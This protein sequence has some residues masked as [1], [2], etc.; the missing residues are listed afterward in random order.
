[1][2]LDAVPPGTDPRRMRPTVAA[3]ESPS[4]FATSTALVGM[5][6][7]W[8]ITPKKMGNGRFATRARS[9]MVK[10]RPIENMM[11]ISNC[12]VYCPIGSKVLGL[13]KATK[14]QA[15]MTIGK[16]YTAS[17]SPVSPDVCGFATVFPFQKVSHYM[18]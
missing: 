10:V 7:N 1:M 3:S 15:M 2:T 13:M 5:M 12:E 18:N 4:S 8:Q 6:A 11:T 9:G 16:I 14:A 17:F